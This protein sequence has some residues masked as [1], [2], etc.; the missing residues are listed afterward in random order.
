MGRLERG[1]PKCFRGSWASIN[2][3]THRGTHTTHTNW[4]RV[5][6]SAWKLGSA[7]EG[8]PLWQEQVELELEMV[9]RGASKYR[10]RLQKAQDKE[11]MTALKPY[12]RVMEDMVDSMG[13]GLRAWLNAVAKAGKTKKNYARGIA[14]Q[15]LMES[16]LDPYLV[17][18]V[19]VREVLDNCTI[20][21]VTL[22]GVARQI[23]LAVEHE[24]S[25][26]VWTEAA[27]GL[28]KD[29]QRKLKN[30]KATAQHRK[31]VNINVFNRLVR[32][33]EGAPRW[34]GDEKLHTGLKLLEILSR[35]SGHIMLVPD[36]EV[37]TK[38]S[39][40]KKT[41]RFVKKSPPLLV[42]PSDELMQYLKEA[43]ENSETLEPQYLPCLMPP[44]RWEGVRR[45]GYYTPM[46]R[47][48]RLIRF[49]ADNEETQGAAT[50]E[51]DALDMPRVFDAL[52]H[53][54]EVPWRVN[55]RVLA[56]VLEA[57]SRD[58]GI[59]G[60]AKQEPLP[61]PPPNP[62]QRRPDL[63]G[64]E[65]RKAEQAWIADHGEMFTAWRKDAAKVYGENARRVSHAMSTAT[66]I[67][68]AERFA[69]REFYFPHMLDFRGRMYPIP[70]YLQPQ[71][72]DLA[73]GLLTFAQG[74]PVGN[75][76]IGWLQVHLAN[77]WGEDKV[78][79]EAR[80]DFVDRN[81][82]MW[83]RIYE[84]PL[85]NLEWTTDNGKPRKDAW[86]AL[87]AI[88]E[89]VRVCI[90]ENP[91]EA[92]SS[93]PIRV[94]GTC[95]GIQHLS[96]M[97]R[98]EVG[99]ASVNL[100]PSPA[101]RDI[102]GES[103][104]I[105]LDRLEIIVDG[106]GPAGAMAATWLRGFGGTI[107]RSFPKRPVMVTPY[108][109]TREAYKKYVLKWLQEEGPEVIPETER[110]AATLFIVPHLWDAV[111]GKVQQARVCME[112]LQKCAK[113]VAETGQPLW[114]TTK[115][116]FHV[117]HFYGK[118]R[119]RQLETLVDGKRVQVVDYERTKELSS[120]D[121]LQGIAPNFVHSQ[122]A[123]VNM[124]TILAFMSDAIDP[125][126][127]TSIHDAFG[128]VA[129]CM[130]DLFGHIRTAFVEIHKEDVLAEFRGK[131]VAM[132]RDH[133]KATCPG[134]D[135][136]TCWE[137]AEDALPPVPQRGALK[138]EEVLDADYFFA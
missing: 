76:G 6:M 90:S 26:K 121:Q 83:A 100:Q 60:L 64:E 113:V 108:G 79:Y 50:D 130:W 32:A 39:R 89:Y 15:M 111:A 71:G 125:P 110:F 5:G 34:S 2:P 59:A 88:F 120:K 136:S 126:P 131:C 53:I 85:R 112:W 107:P 124:E 77:C 123:A 11:E 86:Q 24:A 61:L 65:R 27:P 17:A 70:I 72:N 66:T 21:K 122:D 30:Q 49:H 115:T 101:P 87:A 127:F 33:N 20:R 103:G 43:V 4:E 138:L 14:Y 7:P 109:G 35:T 105:L 41:G 57:W 104:D 75:A 44:K 28:F 68:I 31:R 73:R 63:K 84:D 51:Y 96:A 117:R 58:M 55:K 137:K 97:M 69:D 16:K 119:K 94:D 25:M 116:G 47:V 12:R 40:S 3:Q 92:I 48:P 13:A 36:P 93:L 22:L 81:W 82:D 95:N 45:G 91:A 132:M 106:G 18:Y 23:G 78:S 99:G 98:D 52:H 80:M 37:R 114:W 19:T 102:Y 62:G 118:V 29:T 133:Y 10:E 46:V 74:R 42:M 128:T 8:H 129:G 1:G 134:W 67:E 135:F 38:S 56:V 54:Q 9:D